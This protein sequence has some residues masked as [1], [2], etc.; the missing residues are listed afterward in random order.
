MSRSKHTRPDH[1]LA[2]DRVRAPYEPRSRG[3]RS[4]LRADARSLKQAGA[5][6]GTR[7]VFDISHAT[8]EHSP[9]PLPRIVL[10]RPR[11]GF[12]HPALRRNI[13]HLLRFFGEQHTYG[14]RRIVLGRGDDASRTFA[15]PGRLAVGTLL[16]PGT[17]I[18]YEQPRP[19]WVL[20]G[21]LRP[22]DHARLARAG[23]VLEMLGQGHH[24]VVHWPGTTLRDFVLFD[25]L[26]HEIAHHTIQQFKGK[27]AVRVLRTADH[28]AIADR[29]AHKCRLRYTQYMGNRCEKGAS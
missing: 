6:P 14:L 5:I 8:A 19:P 23:A 28:E 13:E 4:S 25:G 10:K 16:V 7:Q 11:E 27:R 12:F 21:R 18:L 1:I 15:G 26:M 24:T 3:D 2:A 20:S 22:E 29:F 17:I 9:T